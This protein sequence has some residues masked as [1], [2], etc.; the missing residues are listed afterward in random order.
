MQRVR[1]WLELNYTI[2]FEN[3]S[4][5]EKQPAR[6]SGINFTNWQP[7]EFKKLL[8]FVLLC[9]LRQNPFRKA[10]LSKPGEQERVH[11]RC[12]ALFLSSLPDSY[13]CNFITE[14]E[15]RALDTADAAASQAGLGNELKLVALPAAST[16]SDSV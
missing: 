9:K 11:S 14:E 6:P 3:D 10:L 8:N 1:H 2:C 12:D 13:V 15:A 7:K 16:Q 4:T 5:L